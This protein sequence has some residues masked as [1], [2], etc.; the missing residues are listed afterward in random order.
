MSGTEAWFL[1]LSICECGE[2]CSGRELSVL[3]FREGV[4]LTKEV[5]FELCLRIKDVGHQRWDS[6][7]GRSIPGGSSL[8]QG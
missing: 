4:I 5:T 1:E 3:G 8:S 2:R 7:A 6:P